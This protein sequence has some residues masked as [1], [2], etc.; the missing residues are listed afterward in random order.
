METASPGQPGTFPLPSVGQYMGKSEPFQGTD[1]GCLCFLSSVFIQL[2]SF[3]VYSVCKMQGRILHLSLQG[4]LFS[5]PN[6]EMF[7]L[8]STGLGTEVW[9]RGEDFGSQSE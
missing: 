2:L 5:E 4:S 1:I 6:T 3:L 9:G 8:G 7:S